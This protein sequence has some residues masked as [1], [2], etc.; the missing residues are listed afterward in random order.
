M[1]SKKTQGIGQICKQE[2]AKRHLQQQ[3]EAVGY[4]PLQQSWTVGSKRGS[5]GHPNREWSEANEALGREQKG[6]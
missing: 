5:K 2:R 6:Y 3:G 4:K 1:C